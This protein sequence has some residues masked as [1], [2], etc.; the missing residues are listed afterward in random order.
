MNTFIDLLSSGFWDNSNLPIVED[1]TTCKRGK[2]IQSVDWGVKKSYEIRVDNIGIQDVFHPV[3]EP[4]MSVPFKS[5][6]PKKIIFEDGPNRDFIKITLIEAYDLHFFKDTRKTSTL[7]VETKKKEYYPNLFS[8][9]EE[10]VP[11]PFKKCKNYICYP[12]M[13]AEN[14]FTESEALLLIKN[15][16]NS[17]GLT[18]TELISHTSQNDSKVCFNR[19]G[20]IGRLFFNHVFA[21]QLNE[22]TIKGKIFYISVST[23]KGI[24]VPLKY[25]PIEESY[26]NQYPNVIKNLDSDHFYL[27]E[28]SLKAWIFTPSCPMLPIFYE[29]FATEEKPGFLNGEATITITKD[30]IEYY[31]LRQGYGKI[32]QRGTFSDVYYKWK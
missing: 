19:H 25:S 3:L 4:R 1:K 10:R 32:L 2:I 26:P 28:K 24:I 31:F 5:L 12:S 6:S 29:E 22:T 9:H 21:Q 13:P 17:M 7:F 15:C 14:H 8:F 27:S 16:K 23:T 30:K 20:V 18:V 11:E